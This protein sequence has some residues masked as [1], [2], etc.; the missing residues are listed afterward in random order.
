MAML[1]GHALP[2]IQFNGVVAA[3]VSWGSAAVLVH[4]L[5]WP[6]AILPATAFL[7]VAAVAWWLT[8]WRWLAW[9]AAGALWTTAH[10]HM[11]LADWLPVEHQG[12]DFAVSGW[13]DGFPNHSG[14]QVSFPFR[15]EAGEPD[16][17]V[18]ARLRLT[19]YDPPP[20]AVEPGSVLGLV[21][22]LKQPRGL[23]NPGGFDYARW[24]FQEGYGGD[25]IRARGPCRGCG[26]RVRRKW[27]HRWDRRN[28]RG[29]RD[30]RALEAMAVISR[31]ARRI[32]TGGLR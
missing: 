31:P 30:R 23:M 28:G 4:Q 19:W 12:G 16:G 15:V 20:D 2:R 22:R 26:A 9:F 10:I 18:P 27:R 11:R 21:V 3:A 14:G 8:R 32:D 5:P 1:S 6:V 25:G 7:A 17:I 13:V 29:S 24:L